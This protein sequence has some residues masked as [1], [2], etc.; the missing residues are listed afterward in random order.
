MTGTTNIN[1]ILG[2][3]TAVKEVH[4]VRKQS[5][6]MNQEFVA[7]NTEEKKKTDKAKVQDFEAKHR[8]R[9][10]ED[11]TRNQR[12]DLREK[13][14]KDEKETEEKDPLLKE[15]KILDITV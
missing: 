3:G 10:K 9:D 11:E 2:Q 6:D 7:Q 15:G 8:I 13:K 12:Q 4:N 5:L 1:I 14:K